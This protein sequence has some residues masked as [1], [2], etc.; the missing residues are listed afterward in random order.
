M[1]Y[2]VRKGNELHNKILFYIKDSTNWVVAFNTLD[3]IFNYKISEV[4]IFP[5]LNE[6]KSFKIKLANLDVQYKKYFD[7]S[8]WLLPN[9]KYYKQWINVV[10]NLELKS[11]EKDFIDKFKLKIFINPKI[12]LDL[13]NFDLYIKVSDVFPRNKENEK[14]YILLDKFYEK[15]SLTEL[16]L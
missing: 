4:G 15:T 7:T 5:I 13:S 16:P 14:E 10:N 11:I 6:K 3:E 2:K 12:F 1:I 8:G 9:N